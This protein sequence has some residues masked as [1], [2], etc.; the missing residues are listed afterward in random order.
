VRAK[1]ILSEVASMDA[2][3]LLSASLQME[4]TV[5][6]LYA[7]ATLLKVFMAWGEEESLDPGALGHH[8][9]LLQLVKV[10]LF[11]GCQLSDLRL[12]GIQEIRGDQTHGWLTGLV[13]SVLM[14]MV[15]AEMP[16]TP[17]E[18]LNVS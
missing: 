9:L 8:H 6:I 15:R 17:E 13:R 16:K 4:T 3:Q 18:P 11:R 2:T 1:H 7:R 12:L 14:R 10:L 5:A